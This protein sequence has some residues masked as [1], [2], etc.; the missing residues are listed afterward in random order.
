MEAAGRVSAQL[1]RLSRAAGRHDRPVLRAVT[2][3]VAPPL[4]ALCGEPCDSPDSICH[5]CDRSVADFDATRA[6]LPSGLEVV[7]AAPYEGIARK[8]VTKMKFAARLTLAQVA[9]ERMVRAW[10]ATRDG[11]LVPVPAAPARA[12]ARG[13]DNA[14][15]LARLVQDRS[16]GAV[17]LDLARDDGPRQVGRPRAERVADPPRVKRINPKLPLAGNDLWLVDDVVTTGATLDA[18]AA[19]LHEAGATHVRALTFARAWPAAAGGVTSSHRREL[20]KERT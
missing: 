8:L 15:A 4:C 5:R 9:A 20:R 7:S 17:L 19:V 2:S 13:Y 16:F 12:R 3:L 18:C 11:R 6:K 14:N 1:A 10:G